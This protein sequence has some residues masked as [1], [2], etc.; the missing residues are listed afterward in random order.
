MAAR[1]L[2]DIRRISSTPRSS[3]SVLATIQH[4][5]GRSHHHLKPP[6][7][8]S[9][10]VQ[11]RVRL[12]DGNSHDSPTQRVDDS[13]LDDAAP[14][15]GTRWD[16]D[17]DGA[18]QPYRSSRDCRLVRLAFG[19]QR[20]EDQAE[21]CQ[22]TDRPDQLAKAGGSAGSHGCGNVDEIT[23]TVLTRQACGSLCNG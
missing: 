11:S 17:R 3:N 18:D 4:N 12:I 22:F 20:D 13:A 8:R 6:V 9:C 21:C 7:R 15:Y 1:S 16:D 10:V 19:H 5:R 14:G 23:Q 2:R